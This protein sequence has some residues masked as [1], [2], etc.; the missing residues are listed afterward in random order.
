MDIWKTLKNT[1]QW[2]IY[3]RRGGGGGRKQRREGGRKGRKE[4]KRT[5][6]KSFKILYN[7]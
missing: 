5:E 3:R 4:E 1:N 7:F 6:A 2:Y